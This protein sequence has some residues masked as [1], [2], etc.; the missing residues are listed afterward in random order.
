MSSHKYPNHGGVHSMFLSMLGKHVPGFADLSNQNQ[1]Q[2]AILI[3]QTNQTRHQHNRHEDA[4]SFFYKDLYRRFG[5]KQF[6]KINSEVNVFDVSPNWSKDNNQTRAY[7][8][9]PKTQSA[10]DKYLKICAREEK[11]SVKSSQGYL[12]MNTGNILRKPP[13]AIASKA[14][15]GNTAKTRTDIQ[16]ESLT[17]I[18]TTNLND[19]AKALY[20][21]IALNQAGNSQIEMFADQPGAAIT[22][23][24]IDKIRHRAN[25][26][27]M[28]IGWSRIGICE[29]PVLVHQYVQYGTGRL[30]ARGPVN[31]QTVPREIR[32]TAL[33]GFY[34]YDMDNCHYALFH[35]LAARAGYQADTIAHYLANKSTIRTELSNAIDRPIDAVKQ[36]LLAIMYG[37]SNT[38]FASEYHKTPA[39]P[40]YLRG[41]ADKFRNLPFVKRLFKDIR[42]GTKAIIKHQ[43][44]TNRH[45]IKNAMGYT[46]DIKA[47][48]KKIMAHLLQGL[49]AKILEVAITEHSKNIILLQHDGFTCRKKID[50]EQL[51]ELVRDQLGYEITFSED[52]LQVPEKLFPDLEVKPNRQTFIS[53]VESIAYD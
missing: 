31:L 7:R 25:F 10:L 32:Q 36:S 4:S 13:K 20:A 50:A 2:L 6:N 15:D 27:K 16:I 40:K 34:D 12:V 26:A 18:N 22:K 33:Q 37:T 23:E 47:D 49:E 52:R 5:E 48:T 53:L 24:T 44:E 38:A 1:Y 41:E 19:Y 46:I 3:L 17:P 30:Y 45:N 43:G 8:L 35:Q 11:R 14:I 39:L 51:S 28:V 29:N 21:F 42:A 9:S